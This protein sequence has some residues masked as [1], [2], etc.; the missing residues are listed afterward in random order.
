MDDDTSITRHARRALLAALLLVPIVAYLDYSTGTDASMLPFYLV[1]IAQA[2]WF[3][4]KRAGIAV[5]VA[6]GLAWLGVNAAPL[7]EGRQVAP[8]IA[9]NAA[10]RLGLFLAATYIISLQRALQKSLA[11]EQAL[12][13]TDHL[14]GALNARAFQ[15][16][17]TREL[18]RCSRFGHPIS[19]IYFDVDN[20]KAVND[21][22][23]HSEGDRLL[24]SLVS[25]IAPGLRQVDVIA[26]LGGDEF[27][28]L[29]PETAGD[30][31]TAVA[32]KVQGAFGVVSAREGWPAS[33]SVG[34]VTYRTPPRSLDAM[35]K[36]ADAQ[37]YEA[38]NTGKN[39]VS[40]RV[41]A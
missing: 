4:G 36:D 5:A 40:T 29:L 11:R 9:W 12:A 28:V 19:L 18:A 7:L 34:V 31:G 10:V 24:R 32:Q 22:F 2:A 27:G 1:P 3:A 17:A 23:G 39:R 37:M 13:R 33:L 41:V 30:A 25:A 16:A 35:L 15:E 21:R 26:R 38:K 14:T 6:C 20:F 8:A